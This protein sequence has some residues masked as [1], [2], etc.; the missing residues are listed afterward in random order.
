MPRTRAFTLIELLVVIAIIALLIGILLPSLAGARRAA[1]DVI[2]KANMRQ[3]GLGI[4]LYSQTNR[5]YI[6]SEGM[7][8]GDIASHPI[9]PWDDTS[10]W[11]NAVPGMLTEPNPSYY[12]L[13]EA[14]INGQNALPQSLSKSIFVCPSANP[15]MHGAT[16]AETNG[17]GFFMMWGLKPGATNLSAPREQR[18]TYWCY[19][20]NSGLDNVAGGTVDKFGTRHLKITKIDPPAQVVMMVEAMMDPREVKPAFTDRLN[21]A[22]TKGN[23]PESCRMAGRHKDGANLVFGDGHVAYLSRADATTDYY[24]NGTYNRPNVIWQPK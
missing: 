8:D 23:Q 10:F 24:K 1:R 7:A 19:I 12:D 2:C 20:F 3:Y 22:K 15:A 11:A 21:R 5:D 4:E 6:P 14:F 9:G 17:Q 18:P 13:Q 16:A